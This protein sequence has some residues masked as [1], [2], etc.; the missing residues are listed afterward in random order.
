MKKSINRYC[1]KI[2][3]VC[4]KKTDKVLLGLY[5]FNPDLETAIKFETGELVWLIDNSPEIWKDKS[6]G[7]FNKI[8]YDPSKDNSGEDLLKQEQRDKYRVAKFLTKLKAMNYLTFDKP[9]GFLQDF[10]VTLLPD[11]IL[12]ADKLKSFLG[13]IDILYVDHK[14]GIFILVLMSLTSMIVSFIT[15]MLTK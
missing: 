11:G 1:K 10:R 8:K 15:T 13:R 7:Y 5:L 2:K 6:T 4:I 14:D 9:P 3:N 12:R